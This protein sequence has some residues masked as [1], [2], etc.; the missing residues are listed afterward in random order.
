MKKET[1]IHFLENK[2]HNVLAS[3]VL[4][5]GYRCTSDPIFFILFSSE[6]SIYFGTSEKKIKLFLQKKNADKGFM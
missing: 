4:S 3:E 6:L 5:V 1:L 2:K